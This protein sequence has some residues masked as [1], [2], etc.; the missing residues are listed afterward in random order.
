MLLFLLFLAFLYLYSNIK[1]LRSKTLHSPR[2]LRLRFIT[3]MSIVC[4]T[5][6]I[7]HICVWITRYSY[8]CKI[9]IL[10]CT[11]FMCMI[12]YD[13]HGV[14]VSGCMCSC[15]C[16]RARTCAV[17]VC[18]RVKSLLYIASHLF[19]INRAKANTVQYSHS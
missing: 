15:V 5:Y 6:I 11:Y 13:I 9:L 18:S 19:C 10:L 1:N 4:M 2:P 17:Q 14:C 16:A 12:M 3:C 8:L 7:M